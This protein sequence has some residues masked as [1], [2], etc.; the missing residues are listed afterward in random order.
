[1][2]PSNPCLDDSACVKRFARLLRVYQSNHDGKILNDEVVR[3]DG[4]IN[5]SPGRSPGL[6]RS[7]LV[8]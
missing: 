2:R 7:S 4:L 6:R 5:L 1:M 8:R 3:L